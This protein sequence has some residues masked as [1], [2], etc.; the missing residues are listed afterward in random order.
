L[1]QLINYIGH[2]IAK[3]LN[4]YNYDKRLV[5]EKAFFCSRN[6][7]RPREYKDI[8]FIKDFLYNN[9]IDYQFRNTNIFKITNT[10]TQTL[11]K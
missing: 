6:V 7:V 11:N 10:I 1:T 4:K 5:G 9:G 3:E 2:Y 8:V